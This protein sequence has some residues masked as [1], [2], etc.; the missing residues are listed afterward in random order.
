MTLRVILQIV[1]HGDED[2]VRE[3]G[4]LD[5][6]NIGYVGFGNH[7]YTLRPYVDGERQKVAA[8]VYHRRTEGP[9][10]L[11]LRALKELYEHVPAR[12][13]ND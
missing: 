11:V 7:E 9:W 8:T 2:Q 3:V 12:P 13:S 1:P 10:N 5:I 4:R 6:S